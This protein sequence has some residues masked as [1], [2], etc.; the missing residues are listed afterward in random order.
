MCKWLL[1]PGLES[2]LYVY[3][4]DN[5]VFFVPNL[6][7]LF[8]PFF[9]KRERGSFIL[10]LSLLYIFVLGVVSLFLNEANNIVPLILGG[11]FYIPAFLLGVNYTFEHRKH[12]FPYV[13]APL[14]IL[15]LQV[16]FLAN[17]VIVLKGD[18]SLNTFSGIIRVYTTAGAATGSSAI[19]ALLGI[20]SF[21][22]APNNRF[23]EVSL[24]LA[25]ISTSLLLSRMPLLCL[26]IFML[27]IY[28]IRY[29]KNFR[30]TLVS[31]AI[32]VIV[33]VSGLFNP[34][35][36]RMEAKNDFYSGRDLL[37]AKTMNDFLG[38]EL[39]GL[40]RGNIYAT[41]E[42]LNASIVPQYNGAPHNSY[43]LVLFE[44]G[45]VGSMVFLLFIFVL[46]AECWRNRREETFALLLVFMTIF[47]SET[48]VLTNSEYAFLLAVLIML[49]RQKPSFVGIEYEK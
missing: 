26:L 15:T 43:L 38:N 6:L 49:C 11:S 20:I 37:I 45:V 14:V 22:T 2:V 7:L 42:I 5:F 16:L 32:G 4:F 17:G 35:M 27:Y 19:V 44:H 36:Q 33:C 3:W 9:L 41:T 29:V 23:K 46:C 13:F 10:T 25:L 18:D 21:F 12:V 28:L 30:A 8:T 47:N 24:L 39:F 31:F 34:I 1:P 48:V 40:G